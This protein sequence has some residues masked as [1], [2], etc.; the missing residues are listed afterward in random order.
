MKT[1]TKKE[2]TK[3]IFDTPTYHRGR[4]LEE[5][6]ERHRAG[7]GHTRVGKLGARLNEVTKMIHVFQECL[8]CAE[9]HIDPD[10]GNPGRGYLETLDKKQ[11]LTR[12][13]HRSLV[14]NKQTS[15]TKLIETILKSY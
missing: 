11:L 2:I 6:Q 10:T 8:D 7:T 1:E 14:G 3:T 13:I 4:S 9:T 12:I 15:K 5:Q